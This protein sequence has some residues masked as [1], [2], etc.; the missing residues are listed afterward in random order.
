MS[1]WQPQDD[2]P[3]IADSTEGVTFVAADETATEITAALRR[4]VTVRDIEQSQ[5]RFTQADTLWHLPQSEL[6]AAPQPGEQIVDADDQTWLIFNV[7]QDLH[8]GR[9]RCACR[10]SALHPALTEPIDWLQAIWNKNDHGAQDATWNAT[11]EDI[12]AL[13]SPGEAQQTVVRGMRALRQT[14]TVSLA[15]ELA[16]AIGDRF[17]R[18]SGELLDIVGFTPPDEIGGAF[19]VQ[20]VPVNDL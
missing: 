17:G 1:S 20:T 10:R 12:S 6:S 11:L 16:L 3:G 13:V 4:R 14:F 19:I 9:W 18:Q 8:D 7:N 2:F 5:G 15:A